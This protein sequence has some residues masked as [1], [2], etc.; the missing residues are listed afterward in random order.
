MISV[1]CYLGMQAKN[2]EGG[3]VAEGQDAVHHRR[4]TRHRAGDRAESRRRRRQYRH[5]RQ[6]RRAR[7]PSSKAPSTPPPPR[8]RRPAGGRLP[9]AVDVREEAAVKAAIDETA[10]RFGGIDI[11]VNN[12]SAI[13]LTPVAADR[14]APLRPDASDQCARHLH[15]VEI[16]ACPSG[17]GREPAHPDAVAAARHAGEMVRALHRLFDGEVRHEP[18]GAGARRRIARARSRSTRCGRAPPS[19]P[20]RSRTCSAATR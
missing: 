10:A 5:R 17:E 9:L 18:G 13:Q 20:P 14:H 12:A 3:N 6:D 19:P 2:C 8:S 7:I 16:C 11:V 4:L 1:R 15:G